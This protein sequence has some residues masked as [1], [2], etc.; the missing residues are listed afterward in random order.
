MAGALDGLTGRNVY[1]PGPNLNP[2]VYDYFQQGQQAVQTVFDQQ[3]KDRQEILNERYRQELLLAAER[4]RELDSLLSPELVRREHELKLGQQAATLY[5]AQQKIAKEGPERPVYEPLPGVP[6][7]QPATPNFFINPGRPAF[8]PGSPLPASQALFGMRPGADSA[9]PAPAAGAQSSPPIP[10]DSLP[11]DGQAP[12]PKRLP[13]SSATASVKQHGYWRGPGDWVADPKAPTWRIAPLVDPIR[14]ENG[15]I[16]GHMTGDTFRPLSAARSRAAGMTP[17]QVEQLKLARAREERLRQ[18]YGQAK[19]VFDSMTRLGGDVK[20]ATGR[21]FGEFAA[22]GAE[23]THGRT[24][25][26]LPETGRAFGQEGVTLAV[27]PDQ[28]P[29][30]SRVRIPS[31]ADIS[32]NGDGVFVAHD[33]GG[34]VRRRRASGGK[35]PVLDVFV[36]GP[37]KARAQARQREL[38]ARTGVGGLDYM[39]GGALA[40]TAGGAIAQTVPALQR[41]LARGLL[42]AGLATGAN[43]ATSA[44][45][46]SL[47]GE[48]PFSLPAFLGGDLPFGLL[49]G[50]SAAREARRFLPPTGKPAETPPSERAPSTP[51][52]EPTARERTPAK[53][54]ADLSEDLI[55]GEGKEERRR[56]ARAKRRRV[57]SVCELQGYGLLHARA[58]RRVASELT[59][60]AESHFR[61]QIGDGALWF[62]HGCGKLNLLGR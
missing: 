35:L 5:G 20:A 30:G 4:K 58:G 38:A 19:P 23:D 57:R 12:F 7:A 52:A 39:A 8:D 14:D 10:P 24:A 36:D 22:T 6:Q 26:P 48:E 16:Q 44:G 27:D 3:A 60:H 15:S 11:D 2:S 21:D 25:A 53:P 33:T 40:G 45:V 31:L 32:R 50:K 62:S 56:N 17:Y 28:I 34:D 55:P 61:F 1:A 18:T 41:P 9:Q 37:D 29:Y 43:A 46:R 54:E 51:A 47:E 59:G 13:R 42:E 49:H